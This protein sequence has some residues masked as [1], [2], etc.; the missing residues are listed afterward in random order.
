M[1]PLRDALNINYLGP[2]RLLDF[3]HECEN[4]ECLVHVSSAYVNCN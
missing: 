4:V 3:V 2:L 1:E